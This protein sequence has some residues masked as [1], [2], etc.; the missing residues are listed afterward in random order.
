M[1]ATIGKTFINGKQFTT[2]P[3]IQRAWPPRRS[4]L[5]GIGG[6]STQQDFGR[7]AQD[8][9]LTLSSG[10]NYINQA[11]ASYVDGLMLTRKQKFAYLDYQGTDADVVIVDFVATPTFIRDGAGV[12][13]Q[14]QMVLDVMTLRKLHFATYTGS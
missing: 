2:D 6:S 4:R 3:Q 10:P 12:L 13:F 9:R 5:P 8:M 11:F 1:I 14:Y 7:F